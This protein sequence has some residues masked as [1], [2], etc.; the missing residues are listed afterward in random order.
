MA[1]RSK[2][3]R[4]V[5]S[6]SRTA[7]R[8]VS[9]TLFQLRCYGREH[10]PATGGGLV[11][12]NHQSFFDPILVGLCCDR[13]LNY[14]AR[15]TLFEQALF[16]RLIEFF[17]AIPIDRDGFGIGGIKET[18]RR[19]KQDELVLVFPEGTRTKDG[20]VG[21]LK[22]G[23]CAIARRGRVPL[24]PVGLTGAFESLPRNARF[25]R[26]SRFG[27]RFGPPIG[28]VLIESLD[29]DQ[30]IAELH[31]R[32]TDCYESVRASLRNAVDDS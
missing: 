18:L 1:V 17:D 29:D 12:V 6:A 2:F 20:D 32:I 24:L 26:W 15:K 8:F 30:L 3:Q 19:L 11:C 13:R 21:P 14:L 27:I 5:Y 10:L 28:P 9:S 16:R 31:R 23:F 4:T 25:P 22:P 7:A